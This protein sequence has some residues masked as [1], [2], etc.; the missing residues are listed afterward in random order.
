MTVRFTSSDKKSAKNTL[1]QEIHISAPFT[2]WFTSDGFFATKP[3]QQFLASEV[4]IVGYADPDNVVEEIGRG[5]NSPTEMHV[6]GS[7]VQDVLNQLR[8]GGN[9]TRRRG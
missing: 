5:S 9:A 7:N 8:A 4:P 2:R 6:D 3:F 1:W